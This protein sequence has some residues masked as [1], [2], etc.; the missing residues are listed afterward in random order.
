MKHNGEVVIISGN[1][2]RALV[3]KICDE[4]GID[5]SACEVKQFSDGEIAIDIMDSVRGRDVFVI[6]PTSG[7]VNDHLM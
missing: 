3:D 2:N 4:L 5:E 6:Q 7:P 1:S